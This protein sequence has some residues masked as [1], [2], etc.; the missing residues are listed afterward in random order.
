MLEL[1]VREAAWRGNRED[2]L[3]SSVF[4]IAIHGSNQNPIFSKVVNRLC[5]SRRLL[6]WN[7]AA[8]LT[9]TSSLS[10]QSSGSGRAGSGQQCVV[11]QSGRVKIGPNFSGQNFSNPVRP[12]NRVGRA[13]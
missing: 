2:F 9:E 6:E 8:Y 7:G 12:I 1:F 10:L 11:L 5:T 13:K 3:C 4:S